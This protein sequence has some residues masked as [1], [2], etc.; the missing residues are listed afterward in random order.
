MKT[1][2]RPYMGIEYDMHT[3]STYHVPECPICDIPLFGL[4][5]SDIG[6]EITCPCCKRQIL[7]PDEN[8][9]KTYIEE[10][11]GSKTEEMEC[12]FCGGK[13]TVKKYMTNGKWQTAGG[14]C[15][16]CG[17]RFIV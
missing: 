9:I 10:N 15:K 5:P 11:T 1:K 13:M 17:V 4:E 3:D 2:L 14:E 8:W 12:M 7:I 16:D 6:T